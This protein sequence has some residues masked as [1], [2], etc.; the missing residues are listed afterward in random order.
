MN[1]I[2]IRR[3]VGGGALG[4]P[5]KDADTEIPHI[6]THEVDLTL[7]N[8]RTDRNDTGKPSTNSN[9][10]T[11]QS[12][13]PLGLSTYDEYEEEVGMFDDPD[14]ED[15][16]T[17]SVYSDFTKREPV[18]SS[19]DD[20]DFGASTILDPPHQNSPC[21]ASA[22]ITDLVMRGDRDTPVPIAC[23]GVWENSF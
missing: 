20:C 19:L 4:F 13:S 17:D 9:M 6:A 18:E 11:P 10:H 23:Q 5:L 16:D 15:A 22:A 8:E 21:Q 2:R 3:G 14:W 7:V 12:P 1:R